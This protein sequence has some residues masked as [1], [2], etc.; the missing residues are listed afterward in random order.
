MIK[1]ANPVD[2]TN[3]AIDQLCGATVGKAVREIGKR[4][5]LSTDT[6]DEAVKH[7]N[8]AAAAAIKVAFARMGHPVFKST[9]VARVFVVSESK[10]AASDCIKLKHAFSPYIKKDS[11]W[12]DI[13][14]QLSSLLITYVNEKV[15]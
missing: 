2:Q 6:I 8:I 10:T 14:A 12:E 11:D 7:T 15:A 9:N 4:F 5:N 13:L 1:Y 3:L